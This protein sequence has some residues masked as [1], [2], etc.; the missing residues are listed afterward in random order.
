MP[1]QCRE[2]ESPVGVEVSGRPQRTQAQDGLGAGQRP[3]GARAIHS[4]LH[5]VPARS[6]DDAGGDGQSVAE[7]VLVVHQPSARATT[8]E[9][10]R[11]RE[12]LKRLFEGGQLLAL[13]EPDGT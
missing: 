4:V 7:R 3:A 11:A 13:P 10:L 8:A 6:L 5:E 1:P 12:A 9:P 2:V